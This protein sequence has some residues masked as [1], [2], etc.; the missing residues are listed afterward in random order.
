MIHN[1]KYKFSNLYLDLTTMEETASYA[2]F[3]I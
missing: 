1:S 3:D 2:I